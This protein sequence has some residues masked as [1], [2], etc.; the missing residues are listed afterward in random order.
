VPNPFNQKTYNVPLKSGDVAAIV[1]WSKNFKPF[2]PH[3]PIVDNLGYKRL[4]FNYTITGL[5][6]N[7]FEP[8]VPPVEDSLKV[9]KDISS[10]Y[11]K[12]LIFWRFDPILFSDVTDEIHY[13][14]SFSRIADEISGYTERCIISFA[15]FYK[16]VQNSLS[17]L[18]RE[19]GVA[20]FDPDMNRK[21]QLAE[22]ISSLADSYGL[23]LQACCC[24]YL[25]DI[26][27]IEQA[28]CI[29]G[30]LISSL[31]GDTQNF[32][33]QPS[34]DGCGC[35]ESSDIGTYGTCKGQCVYCY[36]N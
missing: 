25:V 21:R 18:Q 6:K 7:I 14:E 9:F 1:L 13:I 31:A 22:R 23:K 28:H 30:E 34:R 17:V 26:P 2:M 10:R 8:N 3:L 19:R 27:G 4:L 24:D 20:G 12:K 33:I 36:A 29:D 15:Y 11:G 35:A 16:K 5:P 32:K